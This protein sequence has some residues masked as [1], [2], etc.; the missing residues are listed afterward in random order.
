[1]DSF[2]LDMQVPY[3][4]IVSQ[5]DTLGCQGPFEDEDDDDEDEEDDDVC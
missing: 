4:P 5:Y 1:M 3:V 2:V